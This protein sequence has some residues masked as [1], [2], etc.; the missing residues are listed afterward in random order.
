MT[1][2]SSSKATATNK[3]ETGVAMI[4]HERGGPRVDWHGNKGFG[5]TL[6]ERLIVKQF[7]G[8]AAFEFAPDGLVFRATFAVPRAV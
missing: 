6:I 2:G 1:T 8:T 7:G 4:W 5:S 3:T